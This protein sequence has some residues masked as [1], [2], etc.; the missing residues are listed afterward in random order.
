MS[1]AVSAL[2]ETRTLT[3]DIVEALGLKAGPVANFHKLPHGTQ[4][5]MIDVLIDRF[6]EQL[7]GSWVK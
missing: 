2:I 1:A 3:P 5:G 6:S 4:Q 7:G